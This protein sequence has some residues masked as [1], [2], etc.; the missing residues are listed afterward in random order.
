[1]KNI[2]KIF[3]AILLVFLT[4]CAAQQETATS[5]KVKIGAVLPL[6]GEA[7]SF[8]QVGM[9]GIE[10]AVKEVND[11]GGINGRLL[12]VIYE[13]DKCSKEGLTVMTKLV[14]IDKVDALIGPVCSSSAGPGLPVV[15][16]SKTPTVILAASAPHLTKIGDYI[17]RIY[18]SDSFAGKYMAE[19]VLNNLKKKKAAIVYV[20]N[21]WGQGLH[22]NFV[23]TFEELG[24]NLVF[25]E[26][27]D[28]DATDAKTVITKLKAAKPEVIVAPLY[29]AVGLVFFKQTKELGVDLPTLGGD[30]FDTDEIIKNE[31]SEGVLYVVASI[32]NPDDFKA[33]VKETT[34][35]DSNLVTPLG[36][37][38][39]KILAQVMKESG[40]DKKAVI[41]A[42]AKLKY[43][44]ISNQ[45][46]EFDENGDLKA[47]NYEVKIIKDKKSIVNK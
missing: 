39:I 13:D 27:L 46:I 28:Q 8:G 2:H 12:E 5:G 44:G 17:F 43:N 31:L 7:A 40:T 25:D 19:Y 33:R 35:K 18:P 21:D 42:L 29:P 34:G 22:D 38:A 6:T 1:M 26:S 37:D 9:G 16:E 3:F 24:G 41:D 30:A 45:V 23:K 47:A 10:L 36:Y 14:T 20:K 4:G 32:N 15:Q 11:A